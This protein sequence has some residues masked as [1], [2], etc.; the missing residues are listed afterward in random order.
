MSHHLVLGAG[1]IGR[2][3]ASAVAESGEEVVIASRS[4]RDPHLAGVTP[5]AIDVTD[6][7]A[8][9]RAARGA[10]TVVNALNPARYWTWQKDWPPMADAI[11]DAAEGTRLV[12][13]SNLYLYGQV[14]EPMSESSPVAPNGVKGRVRAQMFDDAM[15][16]HREGRVRAV[17]VRASDYVGPETL[18]TSVVS[19]MV[20][21]ALLDGK[22]PRPPMGRADQPHSWTADLDVARLVAALIREDDPA[23]WGRAWHVPTDEPATMTE[24]CRVAADVAGVEFIEPRPLP[25]ALVSSGGLVVPL[26]HALWETRHQFERPYV[27]DSSRAQA[28]FGLEPTPLARTLE[29]TIQALRASRGRRSEGGADRRRGAGA[30]R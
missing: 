28:R 26:L 11:L 27:L 10:A 21:P 29:L 14:G 9:A 16:R 24:V 8:L 19:G 7:D 22:T 4:G 12:T 15:A 6:G 20:L 23:D 5:V 17:E 3:I 18:A 1:G 2:G 25:R 30:H 13:V